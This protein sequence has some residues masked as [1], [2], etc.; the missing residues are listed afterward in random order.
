[1][2]LRETSDELSQLRL[3]INIIRSC[4][5]SNDV[6]QFNRNRLPLRHKSKQQVVSLMAGGMRMA[7]SL[8]FVGFAVPKIGCVM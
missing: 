8:G 5:G 6:L 4:I 3:V 1:M 7:G 2:F